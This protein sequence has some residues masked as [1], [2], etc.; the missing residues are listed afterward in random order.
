MYGGTDRH[1]GEHSL[2]GD[3][4]RQLKKYSLESEG[5]SLHRSGSTHRYVREHSQAEEEAFLGR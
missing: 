1:M 3:T 5:A 4:L 2:T